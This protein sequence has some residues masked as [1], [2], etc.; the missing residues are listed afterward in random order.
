MVFLSNNSRL[1]RKSVFI[2]FSRTSDIDD[3]MYFTDVE[4]AEEDMFSVENES[5][6]NED[7]SS[8]VIETCLQRILVIL[9]GDLCVRKSI[10]QI[11]QRQN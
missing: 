11:Q 5:D 2:F 4:M 9:N 7:E 3:E 8:S 6:V 1:H 10:K